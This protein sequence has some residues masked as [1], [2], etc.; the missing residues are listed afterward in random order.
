MFSNLINK[1]EMCLCHHMYLIHCRRERSQTLEFLMRHV[2]L[3]ETNI[4]GSVSA[5]DCMEAWFISRGRQICFRIAT[6]YCD[7]YKYVCA[8]RSLTSEV[9]LVHEV[10]FCF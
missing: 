3:P 7:V 5:P 6:H 4:R 2:Y 9:S 10:V 8:V 1:T